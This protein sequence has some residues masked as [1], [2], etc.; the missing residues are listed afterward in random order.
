MTTVAFRDGIM[1]A[2]SC[3]SEVDGE[4]NNT[5]FVGDVQ[6][7]YRLNDGSLIGMS[8][9]AEGQCVLNLLNDKAIAETKMAD[10]LASLIH[11]RSCLLVRPSGQM[12]WVSTGEDSAAYTPFQDRFAAVGTGKQLAYGA[13]E[14]DA[15]ALQAVVAASRRHA[16]TRAPFVEVVLSLTP[17]EKRRMKKS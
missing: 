4:D 12:I 10:A 2:D 9:D 1:A 16:Y 5:I 14:R 3:L 15:T 8:G 7:I 17:A 13:M 6:K 11:V